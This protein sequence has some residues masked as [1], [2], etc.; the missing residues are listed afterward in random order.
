M[1]PILLFPSCALSPLTIFIIFSLDLNFGPVLLLLLTR[2]Q[3]IYLHTHT[4]DYAFFM[5]MIMNLDKSTW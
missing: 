2:I 4:Y 5:V 3:N 1:N